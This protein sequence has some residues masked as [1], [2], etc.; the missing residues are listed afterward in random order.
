MSFR[1]LNRIVLVEDDDAFREAL[2]ERLRLSGF[3]VSA[4]ASAEAALKALNDRFEGVV[5]TDLRMPGLDGRALVERLAALDPDLPV[6]MMT[7]HGDIA[8][9]VDAMKRGAYD[10]LAKPFAPPSSASPT[11]GSTS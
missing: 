5:V 6:V 7:G 1:T 9:A 4:F 10:F 3:D 2:T 8:E 11:P